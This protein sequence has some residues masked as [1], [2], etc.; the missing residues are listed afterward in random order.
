MRDGSCCVENYFPVGML[1][2]RES[3]QNWEESWDVFTPVH[4]CTLYYTIWH[5]RTGRIPTTPNTTRNWPFSLDV[6]VYLEMPSVLTTTCC[7][8]KPINW[9]LL[10]VLLTLLP[11]TRNRFFSNKKKKQME[12]WMI[13]F[14][15]LLCSCWPQNQFDVIFTWLKLYLISPF[16][17]NIQMVKVLYL[18]LI[19]TAATFGLLPSSVW[20]ADTG[21]LGY[22]WTVCM[23]CES[24][25]YNDNH[26]LDNIV[27]TLWM[28][29]YVQPVLLINHHWLSYYYI[30]GMSGNNIVP[31][32]FSK[33]YFVFHHHRYNYLGQKWLKS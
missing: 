12:P 1:A 33:E 25:N 30:Y 4:R 9:K 31:V 10:N 18:T 11:F 15:R 13:S 14:R 16:K 2:V 24:C 6:M 21:Y 17:W 5:R 29:L 26:S 8:L 19:G 27:T 20:Q 3:K 28:Y 7:H 32:L 23:I 22:I